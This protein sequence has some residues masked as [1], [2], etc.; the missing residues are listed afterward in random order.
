MVA[1]SPSRGRRK[2]PCRWFRFVRDRIHAGRLIPHIHVS[3][4]GDLAKPRCLTGNRELAD[5]CEA[6]QIALHAAMMSITR[7]VTIGS[8]GVAAWFAGPPHEIPGC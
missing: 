1:S 6:K 5:L 4:G 2:A 8:R 7:C 3:G